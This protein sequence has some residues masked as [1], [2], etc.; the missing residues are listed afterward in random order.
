MGKRENKV[1]TYLDEQVQEQLDGLT[2]KYESPNCPGV[3]DRLVILKGGRII[4]VE[5]KTI[6][7]KES[8]LQV[9]ERTRMLALG[10][11]AVVLS[12]KTDVDL[13]IIQVLNDMPLC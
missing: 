3:A 6:T 9:R 13:F 2:R 8:P 12:G 1:E 7:G 11:E 10:C 5:L 4:F